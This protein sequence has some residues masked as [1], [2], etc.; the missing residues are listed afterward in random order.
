MTYYIPSAFFLAFT[1]DG[2]N[3]RWT[4][5][6]GVVGVCPV[7]NNLEDLISAHPRTDWIEI[8]ETLGQA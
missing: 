4:G 3:I 7:Y 5:K 1:I 2:Y 6:R 8:E